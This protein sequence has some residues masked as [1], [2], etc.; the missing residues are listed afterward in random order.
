MGIRI[1]PPDVNQSRVKFTVAE[2]AIRFGLGAVRGVG[3]KTAEAIVAER[4]ARGGFDNLADFCIRVGTQ[5]INRRALEAL[6]KCG[7]F[8]S[9]GLARAAL[10]AQVEDAI[11]IAQ[12]AGEEVARNQANLF[13]GAGKSSVKLPVPR[14]VSE[15]DSKEKL[16]NE[17]EALG[18][19]ITAHPLDKY[20]KE[21][22]RITRLTSADLAAM[23]DGS[24]V[25]LAGVIQSVKLRNNK[26]GKRYAVFSLED[27]AGAV[28]AIAWPET[29]Q[30]FESVIHGD[31]PVVAR[32]KLDVDEER[33]QIIL[34]ELRPLNTA[35][36]AAVREVHIHARREQLENGAL[37]ALK[38]LLREHGG[39]AL[40]FLHLELEPGREAVFILG[41]SL[42]VTPDD[43][44]VA[45]IEQL[46]APDSL[47]IR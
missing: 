45:G 28:E 42:R 35:L 14:T 26:S 30:K 4:E 29:Y 7:A 32:G 39:K 43:A 9:T 41:E 46:F 37:D 20:D 34:D 15:W 36:L 21:I 40:A 17:K 16:R 3:A 1:L 33:A 5:V 24:Q 2:D 12:R 19:Y 38:N 18:F 8:D 23:P 31:E 11:R 6:I 22:R 44:F 47:T 13:G 10:A 27:R 25:H